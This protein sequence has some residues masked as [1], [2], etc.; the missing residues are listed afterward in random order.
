MDSV[1]S[2]HSIDQV[3]ADFDLLLSHL[4]KLLREV[5]PKTNIASTKLAKIRKDLLRTNDLDD[6]ALAA[7]IEISIKYISINLLF[8]GNINY[9]K[10]EV[11]KIIEG[12]HDYGNDLQESYNDTFFE[13][14]MGIR[15]S[16]ALEAIGMCSTISLDGICD[17]IVDDEIAIEC[18][19]IHS[20]ANL[21]KNIQRARDQINTRIDEGQA[22]FGIIALDLS[23]IQNRSR[24]NDFTNYTF[25]KFL[26]N[27][28]SLQNRGRLSNDLAGE[29][30][31]DRNFMKIVS[32]YSTMEMETA[33]FRELGFAYPLGGNVRAII[34]QSLNTYIL[35]SGNHSA[36]APSRGLS[37]YINP[38]TS[39]NTAKATRDLIHTL[40]VG[41]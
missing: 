41:I 32:Q 15:L 10:A 7:L 28:L 40:A 11:A 35:K 38:T 1:M 22:K 26:E 2:K 20:A 27:Y 16:K 23:N 37:Y 31:K 24:I 14:S 17:I 9:N 19:Y 3:I 4:E 36:I 18:K 30:L 33:L 5:R 12:K 29:I 8:E 39:P 34:F 13:L 6:N 21:V 25:E